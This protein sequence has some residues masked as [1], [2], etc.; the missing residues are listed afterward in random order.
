MCPDELLLEVVDEGTGTDRQVIIL[1]ASAVKFCAVDRSRIIDIDYV[2]VFDSKSGVRIQNS[3]TLKLLVNILL[4][5]L[6]RVFHVRLRE[7]DCIHVKS[8]DVI[9]Y[10][11]I[12]NCAVLVQHRAVISGSYSL[13]LLGI[14]ASSESGADQCRD[15][16]NDPDPD[17]FI[18]RCRAFSLLTLI[19]GALALCLAGTH[20]IILRVLVPGHNGYSPLS[21]I[22][23]GRIPAEPVRSF[24]SAGIII[25]QNIAIITDF[26]RSSVLNM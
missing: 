22:F 11:D 5:L 4:H 10:V 16:N 17:R 19:P 1:C 9:S 26:H 23:T 24:R 21:F 18:S 8:L 3:V 14:P 12:L 15:H 20:S 7:L 25:P 6:I 13:V 2:A